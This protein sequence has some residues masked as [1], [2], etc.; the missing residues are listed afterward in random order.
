MHTQ[1]LGTQIGARLLLW[2]PSCQAVLLLPGTCHRGDGWLHHQ[3]SPEGNGSLK[4]SPSH[5]P[6]ICFF[7][8]HSVHTHMHTHLFF[9]FVP[10]T[11]LCPLY[12]GFYLPII[13]NPFIKTIKMKWGEKN[14]STVS[15]LTENVPHAS[16][17]KILLRP[18]HWP[19]SKS[20]EAYL[21][22]PFMMV[23]CSGSKRK[24]GSFF[25]V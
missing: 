13:T 3:S 10:I 8:D 9:L 22:V 18:S 11:P 19:Q 5:H 25:S 17:H 2:C 15:N 20:E 6:F 12:A 1:T 24:F 14:R 7:R 23:P 4:E 21:N 16:E